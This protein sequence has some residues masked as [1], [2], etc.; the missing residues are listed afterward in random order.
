MHALAR[1][2]GD[3]KT[4]RRGY[5]NVLALNFHDRR[6]NMTSREGTTDEEEG[7]SLVHSTTSA[8]SSSASAS[9][10]SSS[11]AVASSAPA[12]VPR[13]KGI[14]LNSSLDVSRP[15]RPPIRGSQLLMRIRFVHV[16]PPCSTTSIATIFI[17]QWCSSPPE[18]T[19]G[20]GTSGR[21]WEESPTG[22][23]SVSTRYVQYQVLY[24]KCAST[25]ETR[26]WQ[27]DRSLHAACLSSSGPT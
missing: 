9:P 24:Y 15:Q 5:D 16:Y 3:H 6:A 19:R 4:L 1:G 12:P 27:K 17:F 8:T 7:V 10:S 18:T 22:G 20:P 21:R 11:A 13:V 14:V 25:I 23:E 2:V 26:G